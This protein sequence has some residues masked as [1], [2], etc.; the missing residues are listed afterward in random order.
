M[1]IKKVNQTQTFIIES[2]NYEDAR[3]KVNV[4]IG[5]MSEGERK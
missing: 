4:E 1:N 3:K 5:L 2:D